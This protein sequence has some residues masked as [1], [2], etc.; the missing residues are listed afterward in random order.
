MHVIV[1]VCF[2]GNKVCR[3]AFLSTVDEWH[4][5]SFSLFNFLHYLFLFLFIVFLFQKLNIFNH[6]SR[7][8]L[9]DSIIYCI[10]TNRLNHQSSLEKEFGKFSQFLPK[11]I[12]SDESTHLSFSVYKSDQE[13]NRF[14]SRVN[15]VVKNP[16]FFIF[17]PWVVGF[18]QNPGFC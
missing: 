11:K 3:L 9:I 14:I 16:R 18:C 5:L 13:L 1:C 2:L 4:S 8:K 6:T 17:C 15:R 10:K 7:A 12:D